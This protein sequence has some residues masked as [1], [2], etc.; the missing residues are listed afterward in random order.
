V[1]PV[2]IAWRSF[3]GAFSCALALLGFYAAD[4]QGIGIVL[5]EGAKRGGAAAESES[6]AVERQVWNGTGCSR[7]QAASL[8]RAWCD[9]K[10]GDGVLR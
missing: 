7:T 3:R 10:L 9:L 5:V 4:D 1:T 2:W 6:V 8:W